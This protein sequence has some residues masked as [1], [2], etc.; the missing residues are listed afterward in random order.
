MTKQAGPDPS[1]SPEEW[2][3][4]ARHLAGEGTAEERARIEA[5]LDE[6]PARRSLFDALAGQVAR[7]A[8]RP[9]AGLDTDAA[10]AR[11]LS[12]IE[13]EAEAELAPARPG[14]TAGVGTGAARPA[15][16][17][18]L[19]PFGRP[20][21]TRFAGRTTL[22]RAAAVAAV[23]LGGVLVW[24]LAG[25]DSA[26]SPPVTVTHVTEVGRTDSVRLPDGTLALL[27][28]RSR[29]T[30]PDGYGTRERVVELEGQALFDVA[31]NDGPPFT[32]RAGGALVL[33]LGTRF[34]V[35]ES[36]GEAV[37]VVVTSGTVALRSATAPA[38]SG[39]VLRAGDR[40][41]LRRGASPV[42][43]R[44]AATE[45]DLAWTRGQLVF[46][47]AGVQEVIEELNRWYGIRLRIDDA[48]LAGRRLNAT[49]AGESASDVLS[50][51]GT[52]WGARIVLDGDSAVAYAGTAGSGR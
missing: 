46:H 26:V 16:D 42:V 14:T 11:L 28:P 17:L 45:A 44:G 41:A 30:V 35:R 20:E 18:R 38:D 3:V 12:R 37:D 36:G 52:A 1:L 34:T 13:A 50:I 25:P 23:V 6:T 4:L 48:S 7:L 27:G 2:E 21:R 43:E 10:W 19:V 40:G 8:F 49:F 47:D 31:S 22:L 32:V 9:P 29:L 15:A 5:W 51:I 33:D 39:V 24:Q